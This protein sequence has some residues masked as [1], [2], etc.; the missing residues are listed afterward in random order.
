MTEYSSSLPPCVEETREFYLF[1][2]VQELIMTEY[3]ITGYGHTA[4]SPG[5]STCVVSRTM[6]HCDTV[7]LPV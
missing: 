6:A 5:N 4:N 7:V 2:I 3:S 1:C